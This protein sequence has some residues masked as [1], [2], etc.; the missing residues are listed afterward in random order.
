MTGSALFIINTPFQALC[1]IEAI[2]EYNII[3]PKIIILRNKKD[4]YNNGTEDILSNFSLVPIVEYIDSFTELIKKGLTKSFNK[5]LYLEL[6]DKV[7]IGDYYSSP[8]R[9][10]ASFFIKRN[11]PLILLDDGSATISLYKNGLGKIK[12]SNKNVWVKNKITN[13]FFLFYNKQN[14]SFFS[15]YQPFGKSINYKKNELN[16]LKQTQNYEVE[17]QKS[18]II[19]S[20]LSEL[21]MMSEKQYFKYI[22]DFIKKHPNDEYMYC[23]HRRED[24]SKVDK[25]LQEFSLGLFDTEYTLEYDFFIKRIVPQR[26]IG[27]GSTALYSLKIINNKTDIYSIKFASKPN[28]NSLYNTIFNVYKTQGIIIIE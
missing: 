14:I 11:T 22:A 16:F 1:T 17:N 13:I 21:G 12:I 25:L 23:P 2:R 15:I 27:F 9:L 10:F 4:V 18:Y 19:G 5:S 20:P 6:F 24:K 3:N 28:V 7:F 26:I 8:F